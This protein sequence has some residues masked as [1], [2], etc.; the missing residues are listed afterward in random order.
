VLRKSAEEP[1]DTSG[2]IR[3]KIARR[4]KKI[5]SEFKLLIYVRHNM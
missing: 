4:V 3:L 5:K 2:N 1:Q